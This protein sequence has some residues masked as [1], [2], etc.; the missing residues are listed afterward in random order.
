MPTLLPMMRKTVKSRLAEMRERVNTKRIT[1]E[2][3]A[4]LVKN[5]A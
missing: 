1:R 4:V 2:R 3:N 5:T